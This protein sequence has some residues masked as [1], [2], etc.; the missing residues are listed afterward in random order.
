VLATAAHW[1]LYAPAGVAVLSLAAV[2]A[3]AVVV[4][5]VVMAVAAGVVAVL[6]RFL[7]RERHD[8]NGAPVDPAHGRR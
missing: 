3:V 4:W 5:A 2:V 8:P 6:T 1:L 7:A